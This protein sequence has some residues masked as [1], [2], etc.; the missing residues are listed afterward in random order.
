MNLVREGKLVSLSKNKLRAWGNLVSL[1]KSEF[2][3][4][5]KLVSLLKSELRARAFFQRVKTQC[6]VVKSEQRAGKE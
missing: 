6:F 5:G 1:L 3:A 2:C 4:W